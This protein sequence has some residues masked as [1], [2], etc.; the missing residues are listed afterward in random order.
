MG[1]GSDNAKSKARFSRGKQ[2]SDKAKRGQK[3]GVSCR[4]LRR[5]GQK[6]A[7]HQAAIAP[8]RMR[9]TQAFGVAVGGIGLGDQQP[10]ESLA[11]R[12]WAGRDTSRRRPNIA[13]K[14]AP[15]C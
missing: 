4:G 14:T 3:T 5:A 13:N 8:S 10:R 7:R 6:R 12:F 11:L 15:H 9:A 1:R 2:V